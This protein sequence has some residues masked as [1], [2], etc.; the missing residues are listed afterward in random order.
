MVQ[1]LQNIF[2]TAR[3]LCGVNALKWL[4]RKEFLI[5]SNSPTC[6]CWL[7]IF[8]ASGQILLK[9]AKMWP[10]GISVAISGLTA[11]ADDNELDK[12]VKEVN[13]IL[14]KFCRQNKWGF[15][16]HNNITTDQHLNRSRLHLKRSGTS[17]LSHN[18][19]SYINSL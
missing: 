4:S 13:K 12:R 19:T 8:L 6:F 5:L 10:N 1:K 14:K 2:K 9:S 11:R 16:D 18:F 7:Y 3:K 17:L 15:I